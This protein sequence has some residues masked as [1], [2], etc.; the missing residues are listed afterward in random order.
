MVRK[1]RTEVDKIMNNM[2]RL[3]RGQLSVDFN[4]FFF[5]PVLELEA[6]NKISSGS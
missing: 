5:P 6:V 4:F 2:E 1:D 3:K